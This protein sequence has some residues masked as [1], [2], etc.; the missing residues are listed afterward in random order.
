MSILTTR[1]KETT[2]L[3]SV[4]RY[5]PAALVLLLGIV[6]TLVFFNTVQRQEQ[7]R[8]QAEFE[9]QANTYVA[10]IQKSIERNL[11]VLASIGGLYTASQDVSRQDFREFVK[12]PL[13]DHNDIQALEWIPRVTD[14]ERA[15]YE[16]GAQDWFAGF[17]FSARKVQGQMERAPHRAEYFPVYYVEPLRGNEA[18]IGFD[19]AS[20]PARL[21]ALER[22][23]DTGEMVATGRITL[24]QETGEQNGFLIFQPIYRNDVPHETLEERRENL[25]GYALGVFRIGD[26]VEAALKRVSGAIDIHVY[27]E[28][29]GNREL[30][31]DFHEM[32]SVSVEALT[33]DEERTESRAALRWSATLDIPG[34]QWSLVLF[35][36]PEFYTAHDTWQPWAALA[37]GLLVTAL[38]VAYLI[39]MMN[40]A[41][42]TQRLAAGLSEANEGLSTEISE[43][44]RAEK[45][46]RENETRLRLTLDAAHTVTFDRNLQTGESAVSGDIEGVYGLDRDSSIPS[47]EA[48]L[49]MVHPE[50][51]EKVVS[52]NSRALETGADLELEFRIVWPNKEVHWIQGR[53]ELIYD[54]AGKPLRV[55]GTNMNVTRRKQADERVR[56][57]ALAL[58][59][60]NDAV[61]IAGMDGRI[62]FVNSAMERMD[63]YLP[64][65]MLG[66][67][68]V[69]LHGDSSAA[70]AREVFEA[71]MAGSW[72]GEI[73]HVRKTGEEFPA[74]LST[75]LMT[76][77]QGHPVG[78]VGVVSDITERKRAEEVLRESEERY[79]TLVDLSP[80]TILVLSEGRVVYVNAAGLSLYGA[81]VPEELIGRPVSDLVHP[82]YREMARERVRQIQ[83]EGRQLH[84]AETKH[85]RI[86]GQVVDI[87][88]NGAPIVYQGKPA[89]QV[90]A[91][92]ITQRKRAEEVLRESE[93]RFRTIFERSND[94]IFVIDP[95]HDEIL[96]VNSMACTMMGY[97]R[98]EF[99]SLPLSAMHPKQMP[100]LQ[101]FGQLVMEEGHGWTDELTCT[102]KNGRVVLTEISASVADIQG[103]RR[104]ICIVRDI[105][106]RKQAEERMRE[107]T[108]LLSMGA[109]I[110]EVAHELNNP[111]AVVLGYAQIL[112]AQDLETS[113]KE[114]AGY[115]LS[116]A[117]RAT[118]IVQN[119]LSFVRKRQPK[120]EYFDMV[121]TVE[122]ILAM[123]A[124]DLQVNGIEVVTQL[125][126]DPLCVMGDQHR[127]EEVFLNLLTNAEQ[128]MA[129]ANQGGRLLIR[130]NKRD[131]FTIISFTDNGPGITP[132]HL[133][134]IFDPFVT[135][136]EEGKG[137]GLGLSICRSLIND[138]GGRIWAESENGKGAT[139]HVELPAG[140]PPK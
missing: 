3:L 117:R 69:K 103:K 44:K 93:E 73:S 89:L 42:R 114:A 57:L 106:E 2:R 52:E 20:N 40:H 90:V 21:E 88:V 65:E 35:P 63:G 60:T 118:E 77:E 1:K 32:R 34:R 68:I 123:K 64:G 59:T 76:D 43:R 25:S 26:M 119:L 58:A 92:D 24:V 110:A 78:M 127:L 132:E 53:G 28:T 70:T 18:A 138:Q 129:E 48:F 47:F 124:Y 17:Q 11:E 126:S 75:A 4:R 125:D 95:E 71:T 16:E 8:V 41:A 55:I 30:L 61:V 96:D 135:S 109:L 54:E 19:M 104:M 87:E 86:D 15:S 111:L 49:E 133:E 107:E 29:G 23:R 14:A 39:A 105:T 12:G 128:A 113:T 79:R 137:T 136:K 31:T 81:A 9:R 121:T 37:G 131:D 5:R 112:K 98:H 7:A 45:D 27:D 122:R 56:V 33:G 91:R 140:E 100:Q 134:D 97:S 50:D 67:D 120:I 38:L 102:T 62:T 139:F 85:L 36:M 116:E 66:M 72:A 99:T 80:D 6:L 130:G 13:S 46:L 94:A 22:A 101:A 108:R 74:S 82:E 10:A 115:I 51:R 84:A 83:E